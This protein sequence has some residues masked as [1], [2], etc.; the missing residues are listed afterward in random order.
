MRVC[1]Q[2]RNASLAALLLIAW[3]TPD[4][5]AQTTGSARL[6]GLVRDAQVAVRATF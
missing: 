2:L 5:T 3:A 6:A 1:R 4:V